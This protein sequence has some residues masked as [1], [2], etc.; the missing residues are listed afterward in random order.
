MD[1][2]FFAQWVILAV[3]VLM[4][5]EK[6]LQYNSPNKCSQK[7]LWILFMYVRG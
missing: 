6:S 3:F 4:S 5:E 1:S 2:R 7:L